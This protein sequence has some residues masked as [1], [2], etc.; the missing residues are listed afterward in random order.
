LVKAL[1][2]EPDSPWNLISHVKVHTDSER[3]TISK[4]FDI[5][6]PEKL[7]RK[8][9][10]GLYNQRTDI[11]LDSAYLGFRWLIDL[12]VTSPHSSAH[13]ALSGSIGACASN[14]EHKVK[15]SKHRK[16][17]GNDMLTSMGFDTYGGFSSNTIK[18]LKKIFSTDN[19][20]WE[21]DLDRVW[22]FRRS[23]ET[24][25]SVLYKW[26][27]IKRSRLLLDQLRNTRC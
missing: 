20:G 6:D 2:R 12:T 25:S 5:K 26:A 8:D 16:F 23:L 7:S 14:H 3:T 27:G 10:M 18:V 9:L 11:V 13:K 1:A 15:D 24:I 19:I 4:Y 21:T 22:T 17:I